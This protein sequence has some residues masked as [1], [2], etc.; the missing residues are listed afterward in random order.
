[1]GVSVILHAV[2][3]SSFLCIAVKCITLW[4]RVKCILHGK[5]NSKL[6]NCSVSPWTYIK[7]IHRCHNIPQDMRCCSIASMQCNNLLPGDP[8]VL[9]TCTGCFI[10]WRKVSH[11]RR[12]QVLCG[13][14]WQPWCCMLLCMSC[15]NIHITAVFRNIRTIRQILLWRLDKLWL[16]KH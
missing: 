5:F 7:F 4:Q 10:G 2:G 3:I 6:N 15:F 1:M 9:S 11:H 14:L 12:W 13:C 16:I 8:Q